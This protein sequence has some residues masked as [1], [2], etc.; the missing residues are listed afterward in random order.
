MKNEEII[1]LLTGYRDFFIRMLCIV[2][3]REG[4][5]KHVKECGLPTKHLEIINATDEAIDQL[6]QNEKKIPSFYC[7]MKWVKSKQHENETF[8][9]L[10]LN[11]VPACLHDNEETGGKWQAAV[12]RMLNALRMFYGQPIRDEMG[13]TKPEECD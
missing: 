5:I 1:D 10:F 2:H 7:F 4:F 6:R 11:A 3:P 12:K 8:G 13:R 9:Q